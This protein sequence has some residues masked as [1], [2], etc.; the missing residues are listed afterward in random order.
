MRKI[1][2][3]LLTFTA[4]QFTAMSQASRHQLREGNRHYNKEQYD[5]AE[6]AYRRALERDSNDARGQ[7]NLGNA[8]YRLK[9]Y[10]DAARHY[11]HVAADPKLNDKRRANAFHNRGNSLL[12]D[13]ID[14]NSEGFDNNQQ[15]KLQQA[16]ASYQEALK[17]DPKNDQ[18]RYNLALARKLMQQ[19][20]QQQQQQGGGSNDQQQEKQD[21]QQQGGG[22]NDQQ[23]QQQQNQQ[24]DQQQQDQQQNGQQQKQQH[25]S[26]DVKKRDAER[27]LDAMKN[28]EKQ[29]LRDVNRNNEKSR[30]GKKDKDW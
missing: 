12:K 11:E 5:Q 13:V 3:I 9:K 2:I 23:N 27:M 30:G 17:L 29:T 4:L 26:Q 1:L 24:Q 10:D 15:Q 8:C 25:Q 22:G 7:Y 21:Q 6:V 20:Q 19:A 16:I 28:N 14:N 18:T